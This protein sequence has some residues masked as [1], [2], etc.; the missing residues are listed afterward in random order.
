M[1]KIMAVAQLLLPTQFLATLVD[2]PHYFQPFHFTFQPPSQPFPSVDVLAL[3]LQASNE[4]FPRMVLYPLVEGQ[5][6]Q[7]S[8]TKTQLHSQEQRS[9]M[10]RTQ[11]Y[12]QV[13]LGELH[14]RSREEVLGSHQES[15][16]F[17]CICSPYL[18]LLIN[19]IV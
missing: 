18:N 8:H 17:E 5:L 19:L 15:G 16:I 10:H 9:I 14:V 6:C 11:K 2:G 12:S 3:L 13:S 1:V 7:F 4:C